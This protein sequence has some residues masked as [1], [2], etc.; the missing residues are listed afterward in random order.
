V[1]VPRQP[2]G[3]GDTFGERYEGQSLD[4]CQAVEKFY[5]AKLAEVQYRRALGDLVDASD[6]EAAYANEITSCRSKILAIPSRIVQ[7]VPLDEET[8][9][10]I[11]S[12]I[13]EAL[14][15]LG[16]AADEVRSGEEQGEE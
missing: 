4:E 11:T 10:L 15:E 7:R 3:S 13:R 16:K 1:T 8:V 6:L 14:E 12:L 5:K 2:S 9:A